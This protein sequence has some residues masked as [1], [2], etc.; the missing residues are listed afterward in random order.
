MTSKIRTGQAPGTLERK[1]FSV[2]FRASFVDPAFRAEDG[3]IDRLEAIAWDAYSEGRKA[4]ITRKAGAGYADPD[5]D[6]AVEWIETKERLERAQK[7]WADPEDEDARA[8]H[9]RLAAQRRHLPGRELEDVP[10][11]RPDQRRA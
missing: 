2:R 9:L 6:L 1:E 11:R 5:Y 3:A 7:A 4:P 8:R 10:A